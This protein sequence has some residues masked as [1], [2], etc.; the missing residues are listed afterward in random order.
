MPIWW[1]TYNCEYD[2]TQR[3]LFL[4]KRMVVVGTKDCLDSKRLDGTSLVRCTDNRSYL[5]SREGGVT[6][7]AFEHRTTDIA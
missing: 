2:V 4:K 7:K 6:E 1:Y 3:G 5:R